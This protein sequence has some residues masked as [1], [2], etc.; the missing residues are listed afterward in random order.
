VLA[1]AIPRSTEARHVQA[2]AG[3][4][5]AGTLGQAPSAERLHATAERNPK[6][7]TT[8]TEKLVGANGHAGLDDRGAGAVQAAEVSMSN[9]LGWLIGIALGADGD[10]I[11]WGT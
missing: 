6:S 9:F 11:V 1:A 8:A 5:S 2:D 3:T 4:D 7:G 10:N